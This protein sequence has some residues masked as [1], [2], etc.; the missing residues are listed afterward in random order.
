[1]P[2]IQYVE[3]TIHFYQLIFSFDTDRPDVQ[4][5]N[6]VKVFKDIVALAKAK[7][8]KRYQP[9]NDKF[10]FINNIDFVP[11]DRYI[12]G[13]LLSIRKDLMP[14][15][16]D[17]NNDEISN[18][19][20]SDEQ[21]IVETN[22]FIIYYGGK[23]VY[24]AL[25]FNRPG[26]QVQDLLYYIKSVPKSSVKLQV[27]DKLP[28]V[29]DDIDEIKR[30]IKNVSSVSLQ[31]HK[32]NEAVVKEFP[33]NTASAL[34]ALFN[35][36]GIEYANIDLKF[37][38]QRNGEAKSIDK[39]E[40]EDSSSVVNRIIEGIKRGR[41]RKNNVDKILVTARDEDSND[42]MALFDLLFDKAK[43]KIRIERNP[44]SKTIVSEKMF[45]LMWSSL[46][47]QRLNQ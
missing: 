21:G 12:K 17:M 24:L 43:S 20:A 41:I 1:M 36:D 26:A 44:K 42:R 3:R 6:V 11:A 23:Q 30:R 40:S 7:D 33:G 8:S 16:M 39:I 22:H 46:V 32:S 15:L 28:I 31:L 19:D 14:E 34:N 47:K 35:I 37:N 9:M 4:Y 5:D 2:T 18:I 45:E 27:V 10:I 29:R 25:E 13:K 38:V